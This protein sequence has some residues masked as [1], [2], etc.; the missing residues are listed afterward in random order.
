MDSYLSTRFGINSLTV[1]EKTRFT[2]DRRTM[3]THAMAI[4]LLTQSSRANDNT[5]MVCPA[6][7][8]ASLT[9]LSVRNA[10]SWVEYQPS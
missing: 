7:F 8:T 9:S 4:A 10:S 5:L 3:D 2:D 1:S 6:S